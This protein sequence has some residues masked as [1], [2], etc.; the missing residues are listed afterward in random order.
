MQSSPTPALQPSGLVRDST[1]LHGR[2]RRFCAARKIRDSAIRKV[3]VLEHFT[4][5]GVIQAPGRTRRRHHSS[6]FL[7]GGWMAPFADGIPG[8]LIRRQ[9]NLPV[10]LLLGSKTYDIWT[11]YWQHHGDAWQG[12]NTATRYVASNTQVDGEW[13]PCSFFMEVLRERLP[14]SRR[15]PDRL[16]T[17]GEAAIG[18]RRCSSMIGWM[19]SG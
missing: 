19:R 11:P 13:K 8:T 10:D 12:V 16:C 6:G 5:D 1:Q 4:L 18:C 14:N 9:M 15:S 7:Y 3:V 2:W 17:F